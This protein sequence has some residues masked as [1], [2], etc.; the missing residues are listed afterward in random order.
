VDPDP[1]V[2][3]TC[4]SGGSGSATLSTRA[5][6]SSK[7]GVGAPDASPSLLSLMAGKVR[8]DTFYRF[9][10]RMPLFLHLFIFIKKDLTKGA[11]GY[12]RFPA[13]FLVVNDLILFYNSIQPW[14]FKIPLTF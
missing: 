6:L 14:Y 8:G 1:E 7:Y 13:L 3:K 11:N 5:P 10:G 9:G 12:T 2:P 4:G